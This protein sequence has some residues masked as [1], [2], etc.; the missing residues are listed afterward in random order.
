MVDVKW[1]IL[2]LLVCNSGGC[3]RKKP[4]NTQFAAGRTA[5]MHG[6]YVESI[7][8]F[9]AYLQAHPTGGLASRAAFFIGK[10]HLGQG[11]LDK[12]RTQFEY[13]METYGDSEEARKSL[14]KLAMLSLLQ[15][16]RDHAKRQF[17]QVA[18]NPN[19]TLAPE[20]AAMLRFVSQE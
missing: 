8:R 16:D 6:R 20:A 10:A 1:L 18:D 9:Q 2:L 14:Y 4:V 5:L 13:T 11:H 12:S 19:C 3:E 7:Q 15:G 17:Q